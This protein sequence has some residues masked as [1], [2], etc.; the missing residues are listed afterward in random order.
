MRE[1]NDS[2]Q[3]SLEWP[4]VGKR[5]AHET[6]SGEVSGEV[7]PS[8]F[9]RETEEL[10][11]GF[12]TEK[13]QRNTEG[14]RGEGSTRVL[15]THS[16]QREDHSETDSDS[17]S[18]LQGFETAL[19]EVGTVLEGDLAERPWWELIHW[20]DREGASGTFRVYRKGVERRFTLDGG[21]IRAA[22]STAS[23][24]R[25]LDLLLREG[26]LND[27]DYDEVSGEI[28]RTGRRAG[29]VLIEKGIIRSA[30]LHPLVRHHY[31][32]LILD[33]FSWTEGSWRLNT[34]ERDT[35]RVFLRQPSERLIVEGMRSWAPPEALERLVP[36]SASPSLLVKVDQLNRFG[37][38]D[39]EITLLS[40]CDGH[41]TLDKLLGSSDLSLRAL[42]GMV[43][44]LYVVGALQL[45]MKVSILH[46]IAPGISSSR[47]KADTAGAIHEENLEEE[48]NAISEMMALVREGSYFRVLGLSRDASTQDVAESAD[49][50]MRVFDMEKYAQGPLQVFS[51]EARL[52]RE[53]VEEARAVLVDVDLREIYRRVLADEG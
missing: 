45:D 36:L 21:S 39:E 40:G 2:N 9:V 7:V 50:L 14:K 6:I 16:R 19:S 49:S 1:P 38:L 32:S 31:K 22:T 46:S 48:K 27:D 26:R 24:D 53:I 37:L 10:A 42:R 51:A 4:V 35:P 23:D 44:G 13:Q 43:A 8:R 11:A 18:G 5:E 47:N 20:L 52:C 12:S 25:L 29:A 34:G 15:R 41:A 17:S 30:E 33:T 3:E 28:S